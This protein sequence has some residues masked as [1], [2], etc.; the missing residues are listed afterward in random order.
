[1]PGHARNNNAA[2]AQQSGP[3]PPLAGAGVTANI[4][5]V[6]SDPIADSLGNGGNGGSH[7]VPA[8]RRKRQKSLGGIFARAAYS[9]V[10]L[11]DGYGEEDYEYQNNDEEE[12]E[13]GG[14]GDYYDDADYC[15]GSVPSIAALADLPCLTA[16]GTADGASDGSLRVWTAR[17][18]QNES[19]R[20]QQLRIPSVQRLAIL[21]AA[22]TK[23]DGHCC[24]VNPAVPSPEV[25]DPS[26]RDALALKGRCANTSGSVGDGSK[27]LR[28]TSSATAT[29]GAMQIIMGC[30]YFEDPWRTLRM[31]LSFHRPEPLP[32][33]RSWRFRMSPRPWQISLGMMGRI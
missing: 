6:T 1:M 19:A 13:D 28:C 33:C 10:G 4:H 12:G 31:P 21:A 18:S 22:P 24:V 30:L 8:P 15:G 5:R 20:G 25:W 29:A 14:D 23:K 2:D 26:S 17:P 7:S 11:A 16:N 32:R 27:R 9:L 3:G